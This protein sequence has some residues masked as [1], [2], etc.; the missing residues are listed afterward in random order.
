MFAASAAPAWRR[1]NWGFSQ[2]VRCF[3]V[4]TFKLIS[5]SLSEPRSGQNP[6]APVSSAELVAIEREC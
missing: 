6:V 1:I 4:R 2:S 3:P 5:L